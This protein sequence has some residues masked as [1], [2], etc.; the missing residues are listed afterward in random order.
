MSQGQ[1]RLPREGGPNT[2]WTLRRRQMGREACPAAGQWALSEG[3]S[4][5]SCC[6]Q[7]LVLH[8]QQALRSG[9]VT[10]KRDATG[11][12]GGVYCGDI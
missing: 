2:G 7:E 5:G 10:T 4:W 8:S 9:P 11:G 3:G 12:G 6:A 1:A